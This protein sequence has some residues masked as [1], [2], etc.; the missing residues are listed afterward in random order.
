[1]RNVI[2]F[3]CDVWNQLQIWVIDTE[4]RQK[5]GHRWHFHLNFVLFVCQRE[6]PNELKNEQNKNRLGKAN[7]KSHLIY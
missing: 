1:M 3:L 4:F 7:K 2:R 5:T 6:Y